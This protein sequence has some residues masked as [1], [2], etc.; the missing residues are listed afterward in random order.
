M[1]LLN[2][3]HELDWFVNYVRLDMIPPVHFIYRL[4]DIDWRAKA[5]YKLTLVQGKQ[6]NK[7]SSVQQLQILPYS[8][9]SRTFFLQR[10]G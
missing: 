9:A 4:K 7:Y 6:P 8:V 10:D 1:R 2:E 5:T 3:V